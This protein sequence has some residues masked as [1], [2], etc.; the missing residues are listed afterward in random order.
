MFP[1][2]QRALVYFAV[3]GVTLFADCTVACPVVTH[4]RQLQRDLI[5]FVVGAQDAD[6]QSF[7]PWAQ[8]SCRVRE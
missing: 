5:S 8:R 2:R 4:L 7:D 6:E 1:K 3:S